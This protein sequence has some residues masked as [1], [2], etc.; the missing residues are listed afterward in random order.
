MKE[1]DEITHII[2]AAGEGDLCDGVIG[3]GKFEAGHLDAVAVEV[4]DGAVV[5]E[6]L[7]KAAEVIGREIRGLGKVCKTQRLLVS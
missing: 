7:E 2:E 5:C 6:L 3:V 4:I 1:L